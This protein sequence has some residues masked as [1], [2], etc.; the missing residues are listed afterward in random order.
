MKIDY[1]KKR[2]NGIVN[3][4]IFLVILIT[5]AGSLLVVIA[6]QSVY[7]T[8]YSNSLV[9][10]YVKDVSIDVGDTFNNEL[11]Q[12]V[13]A[14][15]EEIERDNKMMEDDKLQKMV[16][17]NNFFV[18]EIDVVDENGIIIHSNVPEYIGFDMRSG[19]QSREFMCLLEGETYYQQELR[20][21]AYDENI[22]KV[23]AGRTLSDG[24]GFIELGISE[25][26]YLKFL[27][28]KLEQEVKYRRVGIGGAMM[29]CDPDR[30]I[31]GSTDGAMDG[32]IIENESILPEEEGE[33]THSRVTMFG[34]EYFVVATKNKEYYVIGAYPTAEAAYGGSI[35]KILTI[36]MVFVILISFFVVLSR[37]LKN[38]VVRGVEGI[39]KALVKITNG[40]LGERVDIRSSLEFSE[41]SDGINKTVDKLAELID[42]ATERLD[43][44][45]KMANLIQ[46]TSLPECSQNFRHNQYFELYAHMEP[47]KVVGGD[48]YDFYLLH[49]D[50]LVVT[51]ADVSDK[52]I[53]AAMF[54]MRAKTILKGLAEE[55]KDLEELAT[56][57]NRALCEN[58]EA[59]MFVTL[60]IGFIDLKTGVVRYVHAGHTC[61]VLFGNGEPVMIKKIRNKVMGAWP[62]AEFVGQEFTMKPNDMLFLYSDGVTE[63]F[64]KDE[65]QFGNKRLID[66]LAG[67]ED[68]FAKSGESEF[69]Q[70]VCDRITKAVHEFSTDVP[71]SDDITVLCI[72]Y[73]GNR[74]E[75]DLSAVPSEDQ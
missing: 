7:Q 64:D 61:P 68:A 15:V 70:F 19:E 32:Q 25:E 22:K 16:V 40:Q 57:A 35:D 74:E 49:D 67:M 52:G 30:V 20:E 44:E 37:L 39:H 23:Y 46:Q 58:N 51:V 4:W 21:S 12:Y 71:Q 47:A 13:D 5:V 55:G 3:Q 59:N 17:A 43:S 24:S 1:R 69:C 73:I 45:L 53:P 66:A 60:W 11:R 54:M 34:E 18:S 26:N 48:F 36:A 33:Y 62:N 63:A 29:I 6:I 65:V 28:Q 72:R 50:I 41:L 42:E 56:I 75:N 31:I 38:H 9:E 14:F 10:G 2:L 8:Y 27:N